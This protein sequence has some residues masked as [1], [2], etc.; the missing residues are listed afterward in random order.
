MTDLTETD[1]RD[2]ANEVLNRCPEGFLATFDGKSA[3][4]RPVSIAGIGSDYTLYIASFTVWHK[5]EQIRKFPF[6]EVSFMDEKKRSLRIEGKASIIE[7]QETR[8]KIHKEF[9]L[10]GKY[11][12]DPCDPNY[13]LIEI[14]P[15][16]A[17]I[18][19]TWE[20]EYR[21]VPIHS[22]PAE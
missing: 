19:D 9:T 14:R 7:D 20:L 21:K 4:V 12:P 15:I 11:L 6:V 3:R 17:R 18:K 16:K 1:S 2:L 10:I 22:H 5:V 13:T 8:N